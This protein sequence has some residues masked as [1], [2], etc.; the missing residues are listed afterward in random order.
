M[1]PNTQIYALNEF[2]VTYGKFYKNILIIDIIINMFAIITFQGLVARQPYLC[3]NI[4]Y[5]VCY[6]RILNMSLHA[7]SGYYF[8]V[9]L[10]NI[11]FVC[12]WH[13]KHTY[14]T[15]KRLCLFRIQLP[16]SCKSDIPVTKSAV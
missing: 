4:P 12:V 3:K 15:Q 6:F 8:L 14:V 7:E 10:I 1:E 11:F 13:I 5:L 2:K 16:C 9:C